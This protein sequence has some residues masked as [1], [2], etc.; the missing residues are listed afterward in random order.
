MGVLHRPEYSF[1]SHKNCLSNWFCSLDRF[2]PPQHF[3]GQKI[4]YS[5]FFAW[6]SNTS[7]SN[8]ATA[9]TSNCFSSLPPPP[10]AVFIF[11]MDVET[12]FKTPSKP[13]EGRKSGKPVLSG[14]DVRPLLFT[15]KYGFPLMKSC[16]ADFISRVNWL[17]LQE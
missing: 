4:C 10:P 14:L 5:F 11:T 8:G 9:N 3:G 15:V 7:V 13:L 6:K 17:N 2:P 16:S 1:R 12:A